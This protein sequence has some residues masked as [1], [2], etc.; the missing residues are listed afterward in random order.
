MVRDASALDHLNHLAAR[1]IEILSRP[2]EVDHH[3][4]YVGA[5][6]GSALGPRDG[7]TVETLMR[8]ADLALYRAKDDGGGQHQQPEEAAEEGDLERAD[9]ARRELHERDAGDAVQYVGGVVLGSLNLVD[10]LHDLVALQAFLAAF[11]A[12]A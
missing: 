2:Y 9:L 3:T 4:L 10:R 11:G 6:V 12:E 7:S 1:V 8:N 5:S